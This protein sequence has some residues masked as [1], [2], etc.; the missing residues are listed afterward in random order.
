MRNTLIFVALGSALVGAAVTSPPAL[1]QDCATP[2]SA[3]VLALDLGRLERA[4]DGMD[5]TTVQAVARDVRGYLP[6]LAEP[7]DRALA[8]R[9]HRAFG[10]QAWLDRNTAGVTPARLFFA[11]ARDVDSDYTFPPDLV[12]PDDPEQ[13]EYIAFALGAGRREKVTIPSGWE[14]RVDGRPD[15]ERPLDWPTLVQWLDADGRLVLSRYL[16]PADPTPAPPGAPVAKAPEPPP[17]P[18]ATAPPAPAPTAPAPPPATVEREP[19]PFLLVGAA[20]G[21][22]QVQWEQR[23]KETNPD[24]IYGQD[25]VGGAASP[26][27]ALTANVHA[28]RLPWFGWNAEVAL[29]RLT[30]DRLTLCENE[31]LD[32]RGQ[33]TVTWLDGR[34][35][36]TARAPIRLGA[37]TFLAVSGHLGIGFDTPLLIDADGQV[38]NALQ[39]PSYALNG[40]MMVPLVFGGELGLLAHN[41]QVRLRYLEE[42]ATWGH[43]GT[44]VDA[45]LSWRLAGATYLRLGADLSFRDGVVV[46]GARHIENRI[47]GVVGI[48]LGF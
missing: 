31:D 43:W 25:A 37:R 22:W 38:G 28:R 3:A 21:V 13:R 23:D 16:L 41:A 15:A 42:R 36:L 11:A 9:L 30:V 46:Y 7:V 35:L 39:A 40:S 44:H 45:D 48:D 1:A 12:G 2:S 8:G 17:A 34:T 29:G 20:V 6:C 10:L 4:Y 18:V 5:P 32:C 24:D 47:G 14:F 27:V 26:G 19:P 33:P